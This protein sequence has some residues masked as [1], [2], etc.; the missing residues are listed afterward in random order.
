MR[1]VRRTIAFVLMMLLTTAGASS[2][3]SAKAVYIIDDGTTRTTVESSSYVPSSAIEKAGLEVSALDQVSTEHNDN[4][5]IEIRI[6]RSQE[7]AI[8]YMG[9][10]L[11]V[12]AYDETVSDLLERMNITLGDDDTVS[13]N[14]GNY[15]QDG[16]VI[17]VTKYTY[18]TAEADEAITYTTERVANAS[19]A[20]GKESVKQAGKNGT[21]HVTYSITYKNGK[22]VDREPISSTVVTAPTPEIIEYGTKSGSVT[23]GD[24]IRSD[25]RNSDGSGVL[26]FNSGSTLSYSRV[27]TANATAYTAKPGARTASGKAVYVGGIAV[28]PK[29]IPLGTKLYITTTNGKIVY[30]MATAIDTGGAI[31]GNKIDL[32]YNTYSECVQFGR[33][34]CT[35]YVLN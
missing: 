15:T 8:N 35:V 29:V 25:S 32:F 33:R 30:G 1:P 17:D 9:S 11:H 18:G 21:A 31:K 23:S 3:V 20:A 19:M 26:T 24:R 14:L 13:V 28:D 6:T 10:T 27:I 12:R 5:T 7:V 16:M 4:G 2:I 34:N 22:E